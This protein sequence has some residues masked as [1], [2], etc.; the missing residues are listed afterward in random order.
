M[1]LSEI[2]DPN[3]YILPDTERS[4]PSEQN[5]RIRAGSMTDDTLRSPTKTAEIKKPRL[6]DTH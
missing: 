3:D 5:E 2:T 6:L 1:R 4:D